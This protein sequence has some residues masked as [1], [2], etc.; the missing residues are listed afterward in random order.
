MF[1]R[2]LSKQ[3]DV[4]HVYNENKKTCLRYSVITELFLK[5]GK[6]GLRYID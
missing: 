5:A 4:F 2:N 3:L 1:I 6:I